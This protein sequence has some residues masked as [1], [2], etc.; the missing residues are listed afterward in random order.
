MLVLKGENMNTKSLV[1]TV[2][3][4]VTHRV[5]GKTVNRVNT[6]HIFKRYTFATV[7]NGKSIN[8]E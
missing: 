7:Q 4:T 6:V 3:T 5:H 8:T 2:C 1:T